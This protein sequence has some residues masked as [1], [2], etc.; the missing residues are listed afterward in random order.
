[1]EMNREGQRIKLRDQLG[2][3]NWRH[4]QNFDLMHRESKDNF[5]LIH[6]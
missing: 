2:Y 3:S 5:Q 1:M 4:L 6:K